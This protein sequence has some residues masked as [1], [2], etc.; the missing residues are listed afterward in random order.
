V[1]RETTDLAL[2]TRGTTAPIQLDP[3]RSGQGATAYSH[4]YY[5]VGA[6]LALKALT[7]FNGP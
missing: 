7:Y 4:Q 1:A 5:G 3:A 6:I 2:A